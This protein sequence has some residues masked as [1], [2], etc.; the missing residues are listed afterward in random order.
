MV[1]RDIRLYIS[2]HSEYLSKY[3][4]RHLSIG[5]V[6]DVRYEYRHRYFL[7]IGVWF[8]VLKIVFEM[9]KKGRILGGKND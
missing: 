6:N 1:G 3:D 4:N 9:N 8:Y 5:L 7:Q 2:D